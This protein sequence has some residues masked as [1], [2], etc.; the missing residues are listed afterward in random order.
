MR[1]WHQI[2]LN[3]KVVAAIINPASGPGTTAINDYTTIVTYLK[4]RHIAVYGYVATTYGRKQSARVMDE[5]EAYLSMYAVDGI[6]F[7]EAASS[8]EMAPYYRTLYRQVPGFVA[9][10]P[11]NECDEAY[12]YECADTICVFEKNMEKYRK[13]TIPYW[14]PKHPPSLF[15]H[16][17][18]NVPTL[19]DAHD[20]LYKN[21][22]TPLPGYVWFTN[23]PSSDENPYDD[24]PPYFPSLSRIIK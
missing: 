2:L 11:G 23:H 24:V 10:N 20:V 15:Y 3:P 9:I 5:V 12:A 13:R 4:R 16:I 21:N 22:P 14:E 7:D 8:A 17:I 18:M 6:F 1:Y 19:G